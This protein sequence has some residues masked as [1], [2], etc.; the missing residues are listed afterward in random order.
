MEITKLIEVYEKLLNHYKKHP[1]GSLFGLC[2]RAKQQFNTSG[3]YRL[4]DRNG[5]YRNY[6]NKYGFL[7][8]P[9]PYRR[10]G[11]LARIKFMEN[12][13]VE[14]KNLLSEGY[15]DV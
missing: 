12:E 10:E 2:L 14:L 13:I 15:T 9:A 8:A 7:K 11:T 6:I 5:Y 1:E 4:F 3:L